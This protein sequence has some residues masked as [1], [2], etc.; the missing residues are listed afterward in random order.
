MVVQFYIESYQ[1]P[2]SRFSDYTIIQH[3]QKLPEIYDCRGNLVNGTASRY[4]EAWRV[5]SPRHGRG[6][7]VEGDGED[8]FSTG[9]D[10]GG[11]GTKGEIWI[12]GKARY[13]EVD[14]DDFILNNNFIRGSDPGGVAEAGDLYSSRLRPT[15][16]NLY[17]DHAGGMVEHSLHVKWDCCCEEHWVEATA[18]ADV[19]NADGSV[20]TRAK[21]K[22]GTHE[23]GA[24]KVPEL[25]DK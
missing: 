12:V 7:S 4:Y 15:W 25:G 1:A 16:P 2:K 19:K 3:V 9:T 6:H 8:V 20:T 18:Y 14:F 5:S 17:S 22:P 23:Y 21:T 24:G 13:L 11:E 10:Y